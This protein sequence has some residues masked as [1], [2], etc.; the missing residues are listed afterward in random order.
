MI[1][2]VR[3]PGTEPRDRDHGPTPARLHGTRF[4]VGGSL[5]LGDQGSDAV[6][7]PSP[8]ATPEQARRRAQWA[9]AQ[10]RRRKLG[11]AR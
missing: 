10:A 11:L 4:Y 6:R 3:Q 2:R 5:A 1:E 7:W 8:P 9:E